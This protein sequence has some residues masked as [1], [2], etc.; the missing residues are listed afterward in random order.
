MQDESRTRWP[1]DGMMKDDMKMKS[2]QRN[3]EMEMVDGIFCWMC[4]SLNRYQWMED[5]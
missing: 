5:G 3:K 2:K 1:V 4:I